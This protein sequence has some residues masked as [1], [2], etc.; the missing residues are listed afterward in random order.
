MQGYMKIG[1]DAMPLDTQLTGV[2]NYLLRLLEELI[3]LRPR[4]TF[5][6]YRTKSNDVV[7]N[8]LQFPNVKL[9]TNRFLG[10]SEAL[11]SQTTLAWMCYQDK[12]DLFWGA[13][14]SIPLLSAKRQKH[15]LTIHDFAYLLYPQTVSHIRGIYLRFFDKFFYKKADIRITNSE[16][17]AYRLKKLFALDTHKVILPPLPSATLPN[18]EC[19]QYLGLEEK[20]YYLM[21]GTLEPRKNI[22]AMIKAYR[23]IA[24][25][26][27]IDPLVLVGKSGW[28]DILIKQEIER[29][30]NEMPN[31]IKIL[32]Y[33]ADSSLHNLIK[34]AK[35]YIMPS[36]YEGYGLPIAEARS[37]GT[38]VICSRVPEMVEAA[39]GDAFFLNLDNFEV[40][41]RESL[42]SSLPSPK[43]CGYPT[44]RE[45]TI[46]LS[47]TI[48]V[49]MK[50]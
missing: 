9:R 45:S 4:D 28:K 19:W 34:G 30:L 1:I 29:L 7:K 24:S 31:Q 25:Q 12:L 23:K 49:L 17:T 37:L 26:N 43:K 20:K 35:A 6:L 27:K 16:G 8:L 2:G 11:W 18:E 13:T 3:P 38:P 47:Q 33:L 22:C 5:Y 50:Q 46:L 32:G 39:E 40:E 21:V 14:Q 15:L 44:A 41:L 10:I 48:D 42:T 36:L